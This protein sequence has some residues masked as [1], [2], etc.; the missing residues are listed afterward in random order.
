MTV[1]SE[2]KQILYCVLVA[3]TILLTKGPQRTLMI[4]SAAH[5]CRPLRHRGSLISSWICWPSF[6]RLSFSSH[7]NLNF[8]WQS[9]VHLVIKDGSHKHVSPLQLLPR[10]FRQK[11]QSENQPLSTKH[12]VMREDIIFFMWTVNFGDCS[13]CTTKMKGGGCSYAHVI[14]FNWRLLNKGAGVHG[15]AEDHSWFSRTQAK[16]SKTRKK[17]CE[18]VMCLSPLRA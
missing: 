6:F 14:L 17:T 3:E 4:T 11:C 15:T 9:S 13:S 8:L 5:C 1:W 12:K 16:C 18:Y 10:L 2:N 7:C